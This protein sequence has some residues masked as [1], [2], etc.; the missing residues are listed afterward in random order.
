MDVSKNNFKNYCFVYLFKLFLLTSIQNYFGFVYLFLQT[1]NLEFLLVYYIM[2]ASNNKIVITITKRYK[3]SSLF[4]HIHGE[5]T[6]KMVAPGST[7]QRS[8]FFWVFSCFTVHLFITIHVSWFLEKIALRKIHVGLAC[9][10]CKRRIRKT[11][12][13]KI[14][15][16]PLLVKKQT[17]PQQ[18]A[19]DLSF[20]LAP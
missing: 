9:T 10:G 2:K 4:T 13:V 11:F 18:K 3:T 7:N 15:E 8:T 12:E 1:N 14:W 19:L 5:H 20:N 16:E 17:I 6:S